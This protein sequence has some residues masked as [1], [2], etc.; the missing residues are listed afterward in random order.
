LYSLLGL[1]LQKQTPASTIPRFNPH[2]YQAPPQ[3]KKKESEQPTRKTFGV[4]KKRQD[5]VEVEDF[6]KFNVEELL[7]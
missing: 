2:G 4:V 5:K 3:E 6:K 1:L 7:L